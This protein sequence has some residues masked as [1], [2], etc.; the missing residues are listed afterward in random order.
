MIYFCGFHWRI[1][2]G[3]SLTT[4]FVFSPQFVSD[5]PEFMRHRL[6]IDKIHKIKFIPIIKEF[7][8]VEI[9]DI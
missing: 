7:A 1:N 3:E 2:S 6:H 8:M 5:S 4:D 9:G